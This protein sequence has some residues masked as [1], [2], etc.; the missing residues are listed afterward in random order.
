MVIIQ[1]NDNPLLI[2]LQG[3]HIRVVE[4]MVKEVKV[5]TTQLKKVAT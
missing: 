5:D 4:F 1:D 2:A 3:G